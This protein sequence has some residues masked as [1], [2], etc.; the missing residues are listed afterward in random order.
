MLQK[1]SEIQFKPNTYCFSKVPHMYVCLYVY[2]QYI[3]YSNIVE[4]GN[5]FKRTNLHTYVYVDG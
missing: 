3:K 5:M 2:K 4:H 1:H